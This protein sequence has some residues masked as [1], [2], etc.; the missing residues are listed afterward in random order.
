[1]RIRP[2]IPKGPYPQPRLCPHVGKTP[3]TIRTRIMI[4]IVASDSFIAEL[5]QP[6]ISILAD[7]LF[8]RATAETW[9]PY[10]SRKSDV[11]ENRRPFAAAPLDHIDRVDKFTSVIAPAPVSPTKCPEPFH[12]LLLPTATARHFR[13]APGGAR[14]PQKPTSSMRAPL[15]FA[16]KPSA[17]QGFRP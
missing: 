11:S 14:S 5:S 6:M 8:E 1:M 10:G 15:P 4:R 16:A 17:S 13:P 12:V 3:S 7:Y 2:T 9:R